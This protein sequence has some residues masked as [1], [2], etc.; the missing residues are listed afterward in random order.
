MAALLCPRCS[1]SV[2]PPNA[3][4][5]GRVYL[6]LTRNEVV[7]SAFVTENVPVSETGGAAVTGGG[8]AAAGMAGT[9]GAAATS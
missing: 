2:R 1:C 7:V 6:H 4:G 9:S 5:S 8:V 3:V